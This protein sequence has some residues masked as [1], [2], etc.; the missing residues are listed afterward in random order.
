MGPL[1]QTDYADLAVRIV[2][3]ANP[4]GAIEEFPIRDGIDLTWEIL[5]L[6]RV[7]TGIVKASMKPLGAP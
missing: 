4:R 3:A 2:R 1:K 5:R 7:K 6:H